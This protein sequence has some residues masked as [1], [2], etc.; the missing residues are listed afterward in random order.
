M[1]KKKPKFLR[2]GSRKYKKLGKK[3]KKKLKY[4]KPRGRDNKIRENKKSHL[5]KVKIGF[6]QKKDLRGKI[7][8]KKVIYVENIKQ[9]EKINQGDLVIIKKIGIQKRFEIEK[10]IKTRGGEIFNKKKSKEIKEE[11]K[12]NEL[13]K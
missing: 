6:K 13:K 5:R 2:V 3:S 7:N 8:G 10:I 4:R 9:A 11:E 12:K 1:K